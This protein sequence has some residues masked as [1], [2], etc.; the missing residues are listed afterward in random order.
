LQDVADS[1]NG[2]LFING[3]G[4]V[5]FVDRHTLVQDV[6]HTMPSAVLTDV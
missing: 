2:L 3:A 1:E 4:Y 5:V 6:T